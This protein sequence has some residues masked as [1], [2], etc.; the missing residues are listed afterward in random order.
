MHC[1]AGLP[2]LPKVSR[3]S[4]QPPVAAPHGVLMQKPSLRLPWPPLLTEEEVQR[5]TTY[6]GS[7]AR[8][9]L[10]AE[11]LL[12]G[13]PIKVYMLGGSVT[14]SG[15]V[16][17]QEQAYTSLLSQFINYSY[18]HRWVAASRRADQPAGALHRA[19]VAQAPLTC[20]HCIMR[21]RTQR[22]RLLPA[23]LCPSSPPAHTQMQEP[24]AVAMCL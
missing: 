3:A 12:A 8:L 7:G 20:T 5:G 4:P 23:L 11:K 15:G 18:P 1:G 17:K 21:Q 24:C 13:Q 19:P 16:R 9:R 10:V 14:D 6:Y 22:A 2:R